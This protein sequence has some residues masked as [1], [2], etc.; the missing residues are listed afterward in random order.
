MVSPRS[1][2]ESAQEK[3][4]EELEAWTPA[5]MVSSTF[6]LPHP[7]DRSPP[8]PPGAPELEALSHGP[9]LRV[10]AVYLAREIGNI[11]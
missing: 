8:L 10:G 1:G 7:G 5:L 6:F 2:G 4:P 3:Q 9:H 11:C